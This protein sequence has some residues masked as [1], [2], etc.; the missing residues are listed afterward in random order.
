MFVLITSVGIEV[1]PNSLILSFR[2]QWPCKW[3]LSAVQMVDAFYDHHA[4]CPS[5]ILYQGWTDIY[6]GLAIQ[7]KLQ[8]SWIYMEN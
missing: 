5:Y 6:C 7:K 2:N 8:G 3:C 1:L 4:K